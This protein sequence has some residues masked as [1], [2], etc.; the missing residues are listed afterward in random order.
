MAVFLMLAVHGLAVLMM[1]KCLQ[2]VIT[3]SLK[4]AS[5]QILKESYL[6]WPPS[7]EYDSEGLP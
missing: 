7:K 4:T 6:T 3:T 2:I 5:F 1:Q